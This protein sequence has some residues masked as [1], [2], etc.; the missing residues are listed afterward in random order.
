LRCKTWRSE[1]GAAAVETAIV[2]PV[3]L[4]LAFGIIDLGRMMNA[5]IQVTQ[6]A[7][8]GARAAAMPVNL[9][10]DT[11]AAV[12]KA[13]NLQDAASVTWTGQLLDVNGDPISGKSACQYS[14]E[15][16]EKIKISVTYPFTFVTPMGSVA[17]LFGATFNGN[18][19]NITAVG[20]VACTG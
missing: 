4:F 14:P 18:A 3:L 6:A 17:K 19:F 9:K 1:R 7:R 8:E 16:G 5:R 20:V 12:Q 10:Q 11:D 15:P 13:I 2:L